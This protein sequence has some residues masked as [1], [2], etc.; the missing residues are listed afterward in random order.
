MFAFFKMGN[1]RLSI[2]LIKLRH[3]PRDD[4][5]LKK[6]TKFA[7]YQENFSKWNNCYAISQI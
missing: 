5:F 7:N 4:N 2:F 3:N 6:V 1:L